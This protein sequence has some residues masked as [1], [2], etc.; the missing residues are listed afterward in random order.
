MTTALPTILCVD[1]ETLNLS[2]LEAILVPKG[3]GVA[4][5]S[6]G[7]AALEIIA[8]RKIDIVILDVMMPGIDGFEVCRRI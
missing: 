4:L 6:N 2:L 8:A 5:A 1:D 3:Y 7:T